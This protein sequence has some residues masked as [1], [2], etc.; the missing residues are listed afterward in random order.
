LI[1]GVQW[2]LGEYRVFNMPIP[3]AVV[4]VLT[5]AAGGAALALAGFV[6]A[7]RHG[8]LDPS[9]SGANVIFDEE[10]RPR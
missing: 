5:V 7:V 10:D 3:P 1:G 6:W 8:Q 9:N 4:L 2:L